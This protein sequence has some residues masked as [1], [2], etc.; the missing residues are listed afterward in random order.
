MTR[1]YLVQ[2]FTI[3]AKVALGRP[4]CLEKEEWFLLNGMQ[5]FRFFLV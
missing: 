1:Y 5:N 4:V 3:A 2:R